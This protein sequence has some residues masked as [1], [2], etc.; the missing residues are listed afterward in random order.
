MKYTKEEQIRALR[1]LYK[2]EDLDDLTLEQ[3]EV[4]DEVLPKDW[5]DRFE[6]EDKWGRP[7]VIRTWHHG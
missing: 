6:K 1:E 5:R 7:L 2:Y 4:L 3:C